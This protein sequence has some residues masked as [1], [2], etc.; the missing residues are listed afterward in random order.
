MLLCPQLPLGLL[1]ADLLPGD[2]LE[3]GVQRHSQGALS[4]LL[5]FPCPT[6]T[7][8]NLVLMPQ[9]AT[10]RVLSPSATARA[11]VVPLCLSC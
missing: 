5:P 2:P 11:P 6:V 4:S 10:C 8:G 7:L 1:G 3:P 9:L